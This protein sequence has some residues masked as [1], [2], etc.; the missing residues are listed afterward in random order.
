MGKFV[1]LEYL[2]LIVDIMV[3]LGKVSGVFL[4]GY[5]DLCKIIFWFVLFFIV[6][7]LVC[8]FL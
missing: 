1:N 3:I 5:K 4:L 8:V 7:F 6:V 2:E